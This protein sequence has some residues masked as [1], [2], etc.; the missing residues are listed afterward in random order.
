MDI[1]ET[2]SAIAPVVSALEKSGCRYFIGGSVAS[3]ILGVPRTTMDVDMI[4]ELNSKNI[5]VF[6]DLIESEYFF[7]EEYISQ[8]V[9]AGRSFNIIHKPTAF[10]IDLFILKNR[11]FDQQSILHIQPK[12]LR[13]INQTLE[14]H[15]SSPED[16]ILNKLEWYNSGGCVSE[17]QLNDI[18][19]LLRVHRT[20]IDMEYLEKWAKEL[21]LAD[22]LKSIVDQR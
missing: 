4:S 10:K 2:I 22:L 13:S 12:K 8:A 1:D 11:A 18:L 17:K 6:L 19:G 7:D 15:V 9:S 5:K 20:Q 16:L 21:R 3:S 14:V